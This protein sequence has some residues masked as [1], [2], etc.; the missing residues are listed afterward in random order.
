MFPDSPFAQAIGSFQSP[1]SPPDVEPDA[2]PLA[3]IQ[4]NE[5]WLE[6]LR[7]CAK[8]LLLQSTWATNDPEVLNLTQQ[9]AFNL[10]GLLQGTEAVSLPTGAVIP[11]AHQGSEIPDGFLLCQGQAV[12]R[13]TYA[14]LFA[15]IGTLFG[16][17]DGSTTFNVPNLSGRVPVGD[18]TLSGTSHLYA[19]GATGG[20]EAHTLTETEMPSHRH[21]IASGYGGAGSNYGMTWT[22]WQYVNNVNTAYDGGSGA[23]ENRQPFL[24]LLFLIK[25]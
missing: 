14:A 22:G 18:G 21:T 25:T 17:G 3:T 8:Q 23:H 9:R 24:V 5:T 7:G 4:V 6:Y 11:Y 10:I 16:V 13:V 15:A 19:E 2:A 1:V 12:S 20:E